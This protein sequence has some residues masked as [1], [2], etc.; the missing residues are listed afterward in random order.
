MSRP[1]LKIK[2]LKIP[3]KGSIVIVFFESYVNISTYK[4][5]LLQVLH[6]KPIDVIVFY[7]F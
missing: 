3:Y 7:E 5:K 1:K 2:N 6:F 4:L